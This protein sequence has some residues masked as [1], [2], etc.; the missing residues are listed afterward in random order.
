MVEF[1]L[2]AESVVEVLER[3]GI[4]QERLDRHETDLFVLFTKQDDAY[5]VLRKYRKATFFK[6]AAIYVNEGNDQDEYPYMIEVPFCVY[7]KTPKA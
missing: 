5:D 6:N 7:R 3:H 4:S 2:I 1:N